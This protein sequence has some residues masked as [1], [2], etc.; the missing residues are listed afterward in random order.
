MAF[1]DAFRPAAALSKLLDREKE[2]ILKSDFSTLETLAKS[3]ESLMGQVAR[4]QLPERSLK[5]LQRRA[6]H[7]RRLLLASAKGIRT[8]RERLLN[9]NKETKEFT[10]YGPAGATTSIARKSLT[11]KRKA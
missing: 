7:N 5:D 11:M 4:A 9:L 2:A 1:L 3:K 10:A 8:A 6:D